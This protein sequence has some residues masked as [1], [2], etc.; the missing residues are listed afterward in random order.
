M[1]KLFELLISGD[2]FTIITKKKKIECEKILLVKV[3]QY[4]R[5]FTQIFPDK[6]EID[7][8]DFDFIN[9]LL[10]NNL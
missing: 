5:D 7:F 10:L 2:S 6:N 3:S 1:N 9:S 8:S 4:I